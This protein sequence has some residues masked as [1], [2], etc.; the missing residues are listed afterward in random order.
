MLQAAIRILEASGIRA[1]SLRAAGEEAG[2]TLPT[3]QHHFPSLAALLDEACGSILRQ[4]SPFPKGLSDV[5]FERIVRRDDRL[6]CSKLQAISNLRLGAYHRHT[7]GELVA[8][9]HL[10]RHG[11][12]RAATRRWSARRLREVRNWVGKQ[13]DRR[14]IAELCIGLELLSLGCAKMPTLSLLNSEVLARAFHPNRSFDQA[15]FWFSEENRHLAPIVAEEEAPATSRPGRPSDMPRRL[16]A[17][18]AEL[19]AEG[20][21]AAM[22][23][24]ALAAK[25]GTSVSVVSYH[26]PTSALIFYG[27][28]RLIHS[29]AGWVGRKLADEAEPS[30]S[31]A[32]ADISGVR[33]HLISFQALVAAATEPEFQ[34][35]SWRIRMMRGGHFWRNATDNL[36]LGGEDFDRHVF[37]IWL[38]G[39]GL[40][41]EAS[42][43]PEKSKPFLRIR[44]IKARNRLG[45]SATPEHMPLTKAV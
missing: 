15:P 40:L 25:V 16:Y 4:D 34:F 10:T 8:V 31:M 43:A 11:V 5:Q 38:A 24:R 19:F 2:V 7:V 35:H 26:I 21:L 39:A 20:G 41:A 27:A 12:D 30:L 22:T 23:F 32:M 45:L 6:A 1:L 3:V 9:A 28:Y 33:A 14:F 37:S 44:A 18:A 13:H 17:A 42:L 36:E 29:R